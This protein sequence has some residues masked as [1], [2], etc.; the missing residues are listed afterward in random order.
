[1]LI[2]TAYIEG[3]SRENLEATLKHLRETKEDPELEKA[4]RTELTRRVLY[5]DSTGFPIALK[6][7][8]DEFDF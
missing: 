6:D 4:I 3:E 5:Q 8:Q 7:E 2:R 1:M